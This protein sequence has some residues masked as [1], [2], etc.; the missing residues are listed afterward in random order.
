MAGTHLA[1]FEAHHS[2]AQRERFAVGDDLEPAGRHEHHEC[3][4]Q[5]NSGGRRHPEAAVHGRNGSQPHARE[6]SDR[7]RVQ[8]AQPPRSNLEAA[9]REA[10][11][12]VWQKDEARRQEDPDGQRESQQTSEVRRRSSCPFETRPSRRHGRT[13][14]CGVPSRGAWRWG[15]ASR[16]S[17]WATP[18][19]LS[20]RRHRM[21]FRAAR[22]S[23]AVSSPGQVP[24]KAFTPDFAS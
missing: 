11:Q 18:P 8:A 4:A 22:S 6:E 12:R 1:V 21:A 14:P 23:S 24:K 10:K 9:E 15:R 3:E 13:S 17:P 5:E 20:A 7:R 2:T 16:A 19:Q